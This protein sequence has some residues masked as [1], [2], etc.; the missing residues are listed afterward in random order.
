MS[1]IRQKSK[2]S[3]WIEL[4][5]P[6]VMFLAIGGAFFYGVGN[7]SRTSE[8]EGQRILQEALKRAMVQC[9]SIE[10]MYPPDVAYLENNYGMIYD[11]DKYIVHYE[12]FA[13]NIMPDIMVIQVAGY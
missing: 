11:H 13:S 2:G 5:L 1:K 9:Y 10:G 3:F 12:V 8:K 7:V 4:I 6:V